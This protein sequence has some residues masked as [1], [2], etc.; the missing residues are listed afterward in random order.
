M[1]F[2]NSSASGARP[3]SDADALQMYCDRVALALDNAFLHEMLHKNLKVRDTILAV[4]SHD[5]NNPLSAILL[6]TERILHRGLSST[7][8]SSVLNMMK[9]VHVCAMRIHR[10]AQ[11]LVDVSCVDRNALSMRR[12]RVLDI[13]RGIVV[14]HGGNIWADN[15]EHGGARVAFALPCDRIFKEKEHDQP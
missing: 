4:V 3:A 15:A 5:L 11:D 9:S 1:L 8:E 14:A 7:S 6:K 2:L 12:D 13:S 10:L